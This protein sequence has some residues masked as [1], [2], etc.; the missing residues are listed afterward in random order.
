M[1]SLHHAG[2][3]VPAVVRHQAEEV[4]V[5]RLFRSVVVRRQKLRLLLMH[6]LMVALAVL[7][8][9]ALVIVLE[10]EQ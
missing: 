2:E 4:Q 1:E 9:Q 5:P 10:P 7:M 3:Y 8:E 6:L